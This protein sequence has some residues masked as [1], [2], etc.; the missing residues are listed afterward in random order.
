MVLFGALGWR[1]GLVKRVLEVAGVGG[2][3]FF[4]LGWSRV[5]RLPNRAFLLC[6]LLGLAGYVLIFFNLNFVH[7]YY[8]IP[9]LAPLAVLVA[10]GLQTAAAG[11]PRLP[12][13]FFGLLV[14]A[15]VAYTEV[16]YYKISA[17]HVE[18][19]RLIRENTPD[20]ALVIVTYRMMDCRDPRILYRTGR[21]GWSVEEAAL[22]PTVIERL[23]KE[24]GAG[25]WAYAGP[26]LPEAQ[27]KGYLAG[28]PELRVFQLKSV[29]QRLYLFELPAWPV[30]GSVL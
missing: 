19:G 24:Q 16:Y 22:R 9:L 10:L 5:G 4:L 7:N 12:A 27:W 18:I 25:Y 20:S 2:I 8:Q 17:E 6:W 14:V 23:R 11:K 30:T 3:V 28:L 26:A 21:R 1:D 15:N 29:P 13:F